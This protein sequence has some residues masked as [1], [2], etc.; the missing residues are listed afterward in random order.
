MDRMLEKIKAFGEAA[1]EVVLYI[2]TPLA[3]IA[4]YIF[5]LVKKS[6]GLEDRLK[7]AEGEKKLGE[8]HQKQTDI[9]SNA[10]NFDA[11]YERLRKDY[12]SG[13]DQGS[14]P[15]PEGEGPTDSGKG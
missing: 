13:S 8:L 5:Y 1:K 14:G 11:E 3:F 10:N 9:D 15:S 6:R 4:G 12:L 2:L 7:E